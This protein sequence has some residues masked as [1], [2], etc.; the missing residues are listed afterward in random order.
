MAPP[1]SRT[2]R[3]RALYEAHA[4]E[5]FAFLRRTLSE[6]A[7]AEDALQETFLRL[8]QAIDQL[9]GRRSPRPYVFRVARNVAISALRRDGTRDKLKEQVGRSRA[10]SAHEPSEL[11]RRAER[12]QLVRAAMAAL[13]PDQQTALVLRHTKDLGLKELAKILEVSERTARTRLRTAACLLERELR[14]RGL[15]AEEVS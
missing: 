3:V 4:T 1:S 10:R 14:R 2:A 13:D 9:D 15:Y 7:A 11:A 12:A 6:R 5:V 8:H